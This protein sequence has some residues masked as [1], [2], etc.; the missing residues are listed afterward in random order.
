MTNSFK[1]IISRNITNIDISNVVIRQMLSQ[2]DK[3]RPGLKYLQMDALNTTFT[4]D[5]F[6]VIIDKGTLDALMPD[7]SPE[8]IERIDTYFC[9]IQRILKTAGR[10][11]CISLLQEHILEKCLNY[12]PANNWMFRAVRCFESEAKAVENGES[13]MPT[14]MVVCTKF[15]KLPMKVLEI[16][17][18]SQ[19]KMQKCETIE[20]LT[21]HIASAQK[22]AFV[23]SSL[24]KSNIG[25]DNEISMEIFD[26]SNQTQPRYT[27]YIVET[28][29]EKAN[30]SYAAFIV[31]EGRES[32]WLFSTKAGRSNLVKASNNTRL[33]IVTM[34]RGQKYESLEAVKQELA[35]IVCNLAPANLSTRKIPFLTLG[36]DL[37]KRTVIYEGTSYFTG[38]YVIEDVEHEDGQKY[39]R[40]FF[41][42]SQLVIQSEAKLKTIRAR[43]GKRKTIVDLASLTCPHHIYMN[44]PAYMVANDKKD[45]K[46]AILGLGGGA[47]CSFMHKLLPQADITGVDIDS[48]M[49]KI[50][51]QWFDFKPDDKLKAKIQ[52]G[53]EYIMELAKADEQIDALLLDVDSKNT[54]IGMSCPPKEFLSTEI[55]GAI[56]KI[57]GKTGIFVANLVIRDSNIRPGVLAS[58]KTHFSK[59]ISYKLTED[60]NEVCICTNMDVSAKDFIANLS[61]ASESLNSFF[62]RNHVSDDVDIVEYVKS[63][64]INS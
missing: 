37:G 32:E 53:L 24:K 50:A 54:T 49:L 64:K 52:D 39:R 18:G 59:I 6:S 13:P 14:F 47:Q 33:S 57:T 40:L 41:L 23:C 44:I 58:L 30:A 48:E 3:E 12:F 35:D 7:D 29:P 60:L 19:D 26:Q 36:S 16:N 25:G 17:L 56:A 61:K 4:D 42:S 1:L 10:Y 45:A 34:H 8:T 51:T 21:E 20:D 5:Q 11:I 43:N 31:P 55:L 15:K 62:K 46:I 22:A 63:L 2:N 27:I 9:E 28:A 38:D